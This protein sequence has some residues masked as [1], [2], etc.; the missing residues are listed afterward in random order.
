MAALEIPMLTGMPSHRT[1]P[2]AQHIHPFAASCIAFQDLRALVDQAN[3]VLTQTRERSSN[4]AGDAHRYRRQD[5]RVSH[6][7]IE[8]H[9]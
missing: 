6:Q 8:S 1:V 9:T 4:R 3:H 2:N 7:I 5:S